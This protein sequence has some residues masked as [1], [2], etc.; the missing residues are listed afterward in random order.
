MSEGGMK[1]ATGKWSDHLHYALSCD[2][3]QIQR[4]YPR[5]SHDIRT[6]DRISDSYQAVLAEVTILSD[7]IV[8]VPH[9]LVG[10]K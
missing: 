1:I 8:E 10:R 9:V 2:E 5:Q 3:L 7:S 4:L 6:D